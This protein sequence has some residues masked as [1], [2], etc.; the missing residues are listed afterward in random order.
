MAG[1]RRER[2]KE[3]REEEKTGK[4]V[5]RLRN[6]IICIWYGQLALLPHLSLLS[7]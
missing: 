1:K 3:G 2:K 5:I 6:E 7:S 4:R